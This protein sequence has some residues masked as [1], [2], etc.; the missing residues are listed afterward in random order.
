MCLT[1]KGMD[2]STKFFLEKTA[3]IRRPW[4]RLRE[5]VNSMCWFGKGSHYPR[6]A[7]EPYWMIEC[8]VEDQNVVCWERNS[9]LGLFDFF[10]QGMLWLARSIVVGCETVYIPSPM[11]LGLKNREK[12]TRRRLFLPTT[13]ITRVTKYIISFSFFSFILTA[14]LG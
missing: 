1:A 14:C 6:Q 7:L 13:I 12:K 10:Q 5:I 3:N 9:K 4:N 8:Y 2:I 11:P